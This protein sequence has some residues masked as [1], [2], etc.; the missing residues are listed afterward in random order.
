VED[1]SDAFRRLKIRGHGRKRLIGP[2]VYTTCGK[3]LWK[4]YA[5]LTTWDN[6]RFTAR[7]YRVPADAPR[8]RVQTLL[9]LF[10]LSDKRHVKA[11][12]FSKGG[13]R[14]LRI[15]MARVHGPRV[16]F[17]D[18][19]TSPRGDRLSDSPPDCAGQR[20]TAARLWCTR[21]L[22]LATTTPPAMTTCTS[23]VLDV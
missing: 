21:Y 2:Q 23:T 6:L 12:Q 16:L 20:G 22:G 18:E 3:N 15:A 1:A 17:L 8:R 10:G 5:E 13:R 14:R 11:E 19:S 4:E 7:L 9:E